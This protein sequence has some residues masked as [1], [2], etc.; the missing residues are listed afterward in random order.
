MTRVEVL[1]KAVAELSPQ[2]QIELIGRAWDN[3]AADPLSLAPL[4]D[5]ER[6]LLDERIEA[7]EANPSAALSPEAAL[8][9]ARRRIQRR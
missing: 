7:H 8:A 2:E 1:E 4:T 6:T 9:A 3:L 5:A